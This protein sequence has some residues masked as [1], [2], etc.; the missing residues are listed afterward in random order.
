MG[1]WRRMKRKFA[2]VGE[3]WDFMKDNKKWWLL[4]ILVVLIG[5]GVLIL[6]G[7]GPAGLL[8]YPLF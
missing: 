1:V 3:L 7:Q 2:I 5:M 4:P 6:L 8:I